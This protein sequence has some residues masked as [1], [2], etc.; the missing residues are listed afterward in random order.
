MSWACCPTNTQSKVSVLVV[1]PKTSNL[2]YARHNIFNH[3]IQATV[4]INAVCGLLREEG[5]RVLMRSVVSHFAAQVV[6]RR[7]SVTLW[8]HLLRPQLSHPCCLNVTPQS[9]PWICSLCYRRSLS[10]RSTWLFALLH[11][12]YPGSNCLH[13]VSRRV[14][15][16]T[17]CW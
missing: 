11:G 7:A 17:S 3:F 14:C 5:W 12:F 4:I 16:K 1:F 9:L 6:T 8:S 13:R 15:G 2:A 10:L